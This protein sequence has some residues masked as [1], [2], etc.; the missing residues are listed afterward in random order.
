MNTSNLKKNV[1][2]IESIV[3]HD[4]PM[5]LINELI[6]Y[7]EFKGL[8]KVVINNKSNFFCKQNQAVPSYVALEYMAQTIAAYANANR[9]DQ[10]LDMTIGFLVSSRKFKVFV[11][12]FELNS[13]LTIE[14]E[15]LY[16][17]NGGLAA[18][19]CKVEQNG[20]LVAQAKINIFQPNDPNSF[21]MEPK[22]V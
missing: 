1:Y 13:E 3:P 7:D 22:H 20:A 15:Q 18:F 6:E 5:I 2:P 9:L 16:L 14:V 4:H 11:P 17:E 10:N 19:D 8:C 12:Q 21:L